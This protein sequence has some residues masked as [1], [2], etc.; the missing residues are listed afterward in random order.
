MINILLFFTCVRI[1]IGSTICLLKVSLF[2]PCYFWNQQYGAIHPIFYVFCMYCDLIEFANDSL[3][4]DHSFQR[5][6][7][8]DMICKLRI[9]WCIHILFCLLCNRIRKHFKFNRNTWNQHWLSLHRIRII[10][11]DPNNILI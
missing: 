11:Q 8:L 5:N 7:C 1:L 10:V 2:M 6:S 3:H 4:V 9:P